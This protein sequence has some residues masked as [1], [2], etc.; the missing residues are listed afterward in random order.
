MLNFYAFLKRNKG[1]IYSVLFSIAL[2]SCGEEDFLVNN[3]D[4]EPGKYS[5]ENVFLKEED[6][7]LV[8]SRTD[9]GKVL[10]SEKTPLN[11]LPEVGK[12]LALPIDEDY[13]IGY[14]GKVKEIIKRNGTFEVQ[15]EPATIAELYPDTVLYYKGPVYALNS[16]RAGDDI[17][18]DIDLTFGLVNITGEYTMVSPEVEYK[19][20]TSNGKEI[21][22]T[23][24][25][26]SRVKTETE[27]SFIGR[28][29]DWESEKPLASV[30]LV[31]GSFTKYLGLGVKADFNG[32]V[33]GNVDIDVSLT[34]TMQGQLDAGFSVGEHIAD[35]TGQI[36]NNFDVAINE[37]EFSKFQKAK[38]EIGFGISLKAYT[39]VNFLG[40]KF[41]TDDNLFLRVAALANFKSDFD[42]ENFFYNE[43]KNEVETGLKLIV[44]YK[45]GFMV[46]DKNKNEIFVGYSDS[47]QWIIPWDTFL[48]WPEFKI[49]RNTY[50]G[51][52]AY[53][54]AYLI[55]DKAILSFCKKVAV[56]YEKD[57]NK[58]C[59]Y[60][61][62][63]FDG[64]SSL[65]PITGLNSQKE[66]WVFPT[67]E[68]M[69]NKFITVGEPEWVG[70]YNLDLPEY[71]WILP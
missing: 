67:I 61:Y 54:D 25:I 29:I 49:S 2:I 51:N 44:D 10:F 21:G 11:K 28:D 26:L 50:Y 40:W 15:L 55:K 18:F 4:E 19:V 70:P 71:D 27:I 53:L 31:G 43:T 65:F 9:E 23:F 16:S 69:E 14:F 33:V 6:M 3:E 59:G 34:H 68:I 32:R 52:S 56:W 5:E 37:L 12:V 47:A 20:E 63:T 24:R 13:P 48:I 58:M 38:G 7:S 41:S 22:R 36:T 39:D 45:A 57:T 64:N 62:L 1:L 46:E 66:Y 35:S 30:F 8:V 42:Y 17:I 60:E